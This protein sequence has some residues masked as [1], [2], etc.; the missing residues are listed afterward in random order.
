MTDKTALSKLLSFFL[1]KII[2]G[3]A[4]VAGSV[5]LS[6]WLSRLLLDKT[7]L[8]DD[9]KNIIIA[10]ADVL[11]ALLSYIFLF[12]FYDDRKIEELSS[13]SFIKNA[14]IGFTAGIILQSLFILMIYIFGEYSIIHI[15]PVSFL[16]PAFAA[17]FTAGFV[18]EILIVGIFFRL[19]EEKTGTYLA[20]LIL[21]ILFLLMHFNVKGANTVS[22]ITTA[23]QAGILIPVSF[24]YSRSLW[25]PIF[26]HFA[27]DFSEPG[28]FGAINPGISI[29]KTLFSSKILGTVFISGGKNGPQNSIQAL[30]LCSVTV[31]LFFWLAMRKHN[32]IKPSW[33]K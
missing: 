30:I 4:I 1:V 20:L 17:A 13:A 3:I 8:T 15:N 18:A 26:L 31:L 5:A 27:W 33:K 22:I 6:E 12:K 21:F 24:V 9:S 11:A 16:A 7:Q 14:I 10:I 29:D 19:I 25:L 28:I 32:F 2:I 23:I